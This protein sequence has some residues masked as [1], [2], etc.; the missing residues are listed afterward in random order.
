MKTIVDAFGEMMNAYQQ[1]ARVKGASYKIAELLI[2]EVAVKMPENG[3]VVEN[4]VGKL[5]LNNAQF[6]YPTKPDVQVLNGV[7]IAIPEN[8]VIAFV[9]ASGCGKSSVMKL[10][11]RFYDP[12]TGE[13]LYSD[14]NVKDLDNKWLHQDQLAIVQ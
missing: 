3:Q 4:P 14:I 2:R 5:D 11:Q 9:G 7:D 8:K 12:Q 6:H 1:V 13:L 10:L